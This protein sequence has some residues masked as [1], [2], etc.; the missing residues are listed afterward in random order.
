MVRFKEE[1]PFQKM[2]KTLS[3]AEL[4]ALSIHERLYL[5]QKKAEKNKD[6]FKNYDGLFLV[7][8]NMEGYITTD[9]ETRH[10]MKKIEGKLSKRH[11]RKMIL[12]QGL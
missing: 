5:N 4:S 6:R 11:V 3:A 10:N 2:S 7:R 8:R 1:D 12:E 9:G